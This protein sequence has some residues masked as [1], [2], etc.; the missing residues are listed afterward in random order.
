M[1]FEHLQIDYAACEATQVSL[2]SNCRSLLSARD[3]AVKSGNFGD[4]VDELSTY[5][6][7]VCS[8]LESIEKGVSQFSVELRESSKDFAAQDQKIADIFQGFLDDLDSR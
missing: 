1:A 4:V 8:G 3:T 2:E 7:A 5:I 6:T